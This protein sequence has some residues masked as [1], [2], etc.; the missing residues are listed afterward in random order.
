M[1]D[2]P[3]TKAASHRLPILLITAFSLAIFAALFYSA[4]LPAAAQTEPPAPTPTPLPDPLEYPLPNNPSS[5]VS[6]WRPPL[7]P[8]P[9]ALSIHDHFYFSRPV[10]VNEVNWPLPTYR[11]GGIFFAPDA[12]H[13][14]V[15]IVVDTGT[16][17]LAAGPG[18]V[19]FAG[20][21]LLYGTQENPNPYGLAVVI[22]HDFGWNNLP[23]YTLYAHLSEVIA[24]KGQ[25]VQ[26]G[27]LIALSGESGFTTA[28]HLHFEVR[29]GTNTYYDSQ[30]PELWLAPPVGWG[31]VAGK[32]TDGANL[33]LFS[34]D[35]IL[36][37]LETDQKWYAQSYG[38]IFTV[39]Q[40][41]YYKEN[42]VISDLP[43]G[44]YLV[45]IPYFGRNY[46]ETIEVLPGSVTY[47]R[48]KG[49]MGFVEPE[50]EPAPPGNLPQPK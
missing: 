24:T 48:F 8:T 30:N 11:Y 16:P 49:W 9:W 29:T 42:F 33:R 6:S 22:R 17:V 20:P 1:R 47:I 41:P 37:N 3:S 35:I 15:D 36:V 25:Q 39:N 14:G 50:L 2:S 44:K 46:E 23:I 12:P 21:D 4:T 40:D 32:L 31:V 10:A 34:Q 43:A 7:Y 27:D 28:P 18:Q 38:S 26:S 19:I 45:Q 13:T 5:P